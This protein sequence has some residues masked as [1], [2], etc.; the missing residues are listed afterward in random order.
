MISH[1]TDLYLHR[2]KSKSILILFVQGA[3]VT[4]V[5]ITNGKVLGQSSQSAASIEEAA[6]LALLDL[7]QNKVNIPK[8]L[9]IVS[10][11][12]RSTMVDTALN[13]GQDEKM[14]ERAIQYNSAE[15]VATLFEANES[16]FSFLIE[17]CLPKATLE[18]L[19]ELFPDFSPAEQLKSYL[20]TQDKISLISPPKVQAINETVIG[21]TALGKSHALASFLPK[22]SITKWEKFSKSK[23][24]QLLGIVGE[25]S[26]ISL[27]QD[28]GTVAFIDAH[29]GCIIHKSQGTNETFEEYA[30]VSVDIPTAWISRTSSISSTDDHILVCSE[31]DAKLLAKHGLAP[32]IQRYN[33]EFYTSLS[34]QIIKELKKSPKDRK[35]T[36]HRIST[37]PLPLFKRKST[38]SIIG[39]A[40]CLAAF[41]S[42]F[43]PVLF[44]RLELTKKLTELRAKKNLQEAD[45]SKKRDEQSKIKEIKAAIEKLNNAK[46]SVTNPRAAIRFPY[47]KDHHFLLNILSKSLGNVSNEFE[48]VSFSTDWSG[49]ISLTGRA[50]SLLEARDFT[51]KFAILLTEESLPRHLSEQ[52]FD[53]DS[54]FYNFTIKPYEENQ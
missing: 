14:T 40:L 17:D 46:T 30:R 11:E 1:K 25:Q 43:L 15:I 37:P 45:I 3:V 52:E 9:F 54:G 4:A 49:N 38:W 41:S 35:I 13:E 47:L 51:D 31:I 8:A 50:S 44:E 20:L 24:L 32:T 23:K 26:T 42:T 36:N 10:S 5:S 7:K 27:F 48:I 22:E 16:A 53:A 6:D 12:V 39:T 33:P 2:L 18:N 34:A 29:S 21:F 28:E 19:T